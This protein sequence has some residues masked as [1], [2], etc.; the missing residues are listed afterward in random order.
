MGYLLKQSQT[1]RPLLFLMVDSADHVSAKTGLSPTVTLSKNGGAF[2]APSGAVSEVG[3]GWYKV[4]GNGTDAGTLGPLLLHAT[5]TG[6]DPTDERYEVVAFDPEVGT[7]LGLSALPTANPAA[8]GGLAT[9]DASN[10][11]KVQSGTGANQIALTSG[12]VELTAAGIQAIW[13][14]LTSAL[15]TAGSIGKLLVDRLDAA[16]SSRSTVTTAQVNAEVV[17]ALDTDTYAELGGVP[18]ATV[19]IRKAIQWVFML[20]RNKAT[21]SATTLSLRNDADSATIA[22]AAHSDDGTTYTRG[23]W[24]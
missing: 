13:D 15:T 10:A 1:A 16:I 4:A 18:A 7:N 23:E 22:T 8:N 20:Q 14:A 12:K 24:S 21:A 2:A 6:A 19:S 3:S 9:C 17:D 5:A 11:L